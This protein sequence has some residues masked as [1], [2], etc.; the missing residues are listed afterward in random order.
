MPLSKLE[1]ALFRNPE[2][3]EKIL[4]AVLNRHTTAS[5]LGGGVG[6]LLG[7][8]HSGEKD[9]PI[10][11]WR[12]L[13]NS[14]I[15]MGSGAVAGNLTSRAVPGLSGKLND[16]LVDT[17]VRKPVGLYATNNIDTSGYFSPLVPE[18]WKDNFWGNFRRTFLKDRPLNNQFFNSRNENP[19]RAAF[20]LEPRVG[21]GPY[22]R[23]TIATGPNS[24][25]GSPEFESQLKHVYKIL[26]QEG[27][28]SPGERMLHDSDIPSL[29]P[30]SYTGRDR[31]FKF[32]RPE[33]MSDSF[34]YPDLRNFTAGLSSDGKSVDYRDMWDVDLH[35]DEK[36]DSFANLSRWLMSRRGDGRGI[37]HPVEIAG[38]VPLN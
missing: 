5:L 30:A 24:F 14:V 21:T 25:R 22:R 26:T 27:L 37:M 19:F 33:S 13:R 29:P 38:S 4:N 11:R 20:G 35:P 2:R 32:N 16:R 10:S 34:F 36:I 7:A 17:L 1:R 12:R 6:G 8:V 28:A 31:F 23:A 3:T 18:S 15:G 9:K